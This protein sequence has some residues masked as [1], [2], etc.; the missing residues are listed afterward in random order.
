MILFKQPLRICWRVGR[1]IL[2]LQFKTVSGWLGG[3]EGLV[4]TSQVLVSI[5]LLAIEGF[6][7]G[8]RGGCSQLAV[9]FSQKT[10]HASAI[11]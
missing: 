1:V 6:F 2:R 3:G 10:R 5:I 7:G 9:R 11:N 4:S 8:I